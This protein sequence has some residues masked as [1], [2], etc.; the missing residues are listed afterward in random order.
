ML[1]NVKIKSLEKNNTK[2]SNS[3]GA[4]IN[5]NTAQQGSNHF[6][7]RKIYIKAKE[8]VSVCFF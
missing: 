4:M 6:Q 2:Y 1:T 8:N 7:I 3:E 5:A